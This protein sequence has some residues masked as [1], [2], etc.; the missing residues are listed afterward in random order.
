MASSNTHSIFVSTACLVGVEPIISRISLYRSYGLNAIELGTGVSVDDN[1]LARVS[2]SDCQF[3]VHNYFPPPPKPF[4]LNLASSDENIRR[5]SLELVF[6]AL[7][8]TVRLGAPFYSVHAGF[9]TDPTSSGT[10]SFIFPMPASPD[11]EQQAMKRFVEAIKIALDHAERFGVQLLIEN[12]VCSRELRGKLLLQDADEF[13][14]LFK[15]L[16]SLH[17][18]ILLDTGHLNVTAHTFGFDRFSFVDQVAPHIRAF[19]VSDND[20]TVDSGQ[21][22]RAGSWVLDVLHRAEFRDLPIIIEAKFKSAVELRQHVNWLRAELGR[23]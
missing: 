10:T 20:G 18:G 5:R 7:A 16:P 4:V 12:N 22:V 1:N 13:L 3:L 11:V 14:A 21:P 19:H 2:G 23:E 8:L 17:L 9:I 15:A 6:K